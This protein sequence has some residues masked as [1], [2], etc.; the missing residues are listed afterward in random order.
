MINNYDIHLFYIL[1]NRKLEQVLK[2]GTSSNTRF[3]NIH[4][5]CLVKTIDSK[6]Q[7]L[8]TRF[9][10][11]MFNHDWCIKVFSK[12]L[13]APKKDKGGKK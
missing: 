13:S 1:F 3:L 11:P 7:Y 8:F 2:E 10:L 4:I 5:H 6:I 12:D 9:H